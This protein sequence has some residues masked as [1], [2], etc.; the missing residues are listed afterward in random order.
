MNL[1]YLSPEFPPNYKSFILALAR[2]GVRVFG[3]GEADFH[4]MPEGLRSSLAWYVRCDMEDADAF[5]LAADYLVREVIRGRVDVVESHNEHWMRHEAL[6]NERFDVEGIRPGDI[7]RLRKKFR[8]KELFQ[9]DGIP[10]AEGCLHTGGRETCL[11]F[12][13]RAGY[14]LVLKPN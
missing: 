14:P 5:L 13:R 10:V 8:M 12:A 1:I 3:I 9:S 2:S 4:S 11:S 6:L 7:D